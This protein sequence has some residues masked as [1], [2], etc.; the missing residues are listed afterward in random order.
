MRLWGFFKVTGGRSKGECKY[1]K[2]TIG[3]R[4]KNTT[5][6]WF[7]D[8]GEEK[9]HIRDRRSVWGDGEKEWLGSG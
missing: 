6:T 5:H 3:L 2:E 1:S 9:Q 7:R 8:P 4:M